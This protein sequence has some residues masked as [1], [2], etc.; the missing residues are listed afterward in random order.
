MNSL[1]TMGIIAVLVAGAVWIWMGADQPR[2]R[3]PGPGTQKS[4]GLLPRRGNS[5]STPSADESVC[6][7]EDK[8]PL[9][10]DLTAAML[11]TGLSLTEALRALAMS[12]PS[13]RPLTR[14]ARSLELGMSWEDAWD[15]VDDQLRPLESAL[16]FSRLAGASSASLLK[17]SA[18]SSRRVVHRVFEK[19][20]SELGVKLIL[21]LGLCALPAF[22]LLGVGPLVIS[23][24][25]R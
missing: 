7:V 17:D 10:L 15:G 11:S 18:A 19:K 14:V 6:L 8:V 16:A 21:P 1:I 13:C 22:M 2:R 3:V 20:A 4:Q 12:V 24:L 23:L 25:P 9:I 5:E